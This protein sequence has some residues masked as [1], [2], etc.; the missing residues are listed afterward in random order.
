MHHIS[1][2]LKRWMERHE[3]W[4][5]LGAQVS[6]ER[7]AAEI[8]ADLQEIAK[9]QADELVTLEE[10]GR[11]TGYTADHLGALIRQGKLQNYGRK[12]APRV[13]LGDCPRKPHAL[14]YRRDR[15]TLGLAD[16]RGIARSVLTSS[17]GG[18]DNAS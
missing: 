3:E 1:D 9:A 11:Q 10:A 2:V 7:V 13:R 18:R 4:T 6:G 16:R 17:T 15:A 14:T 8:V 12:N 5:R